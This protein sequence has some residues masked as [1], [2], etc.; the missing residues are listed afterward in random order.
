MREW[1]ANRLIEIGKKKSELARHLD[2]PAPRVSEILKGKR[3]IQSDE[4]AP[5][6]SFLNW[7]IEQVIRSESGFST[8]P[9]GRGTDISSPMADI[10]APNFGAKDVPVRG[11]AAAGSRGG[12]QMSP[13][14]IDYVRRPP[15]LINSKNIYAIFVLNDSMHPAYESGALV[16]VSPDKPARAGDYVIVQVRTQQGEIEALFKRLKRHDDRFLVLQQY[17]P[18]KDIKISQADVVAVHRAYTLNELIG[19]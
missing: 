10:T 17:N 14:T 8:M 13:D 3:E 11:V 2:I 16:Y 18:A 12:F 9:D 1:L 15:A 6:A 4:L 5:L 19:I 7:T